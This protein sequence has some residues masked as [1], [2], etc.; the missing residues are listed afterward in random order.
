MRAC[1]DCGK[2]TEGSRCPEH[3]RAKERKR[4]RRAKA[5]G[6][7]GARGSTAASRSRRARV[8][9]R[10][11]H[12]CRYCGV[13]AT[14]ADHFVP[15]AKGGQDEED[16]LVAACEPCNSAKADSMPQEFLASEWLAERRAQQIALRA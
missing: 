6:L 13:A 4:A 12:R 15:L 3:A 11:G 2:P 16:N 10:A 14:I 8:L 7:T 1:L 9:E 5:L